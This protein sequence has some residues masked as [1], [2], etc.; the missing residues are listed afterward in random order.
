MQG[1]S[2]PEVNASRC[3]TGLIS[4]LGA[5]LSAGQRNDWPWFKEAWDAAMVKVYKGAWAEQ[6]S[7]WVQQV[8]CDKR[9]NAFSEFVYHETLRVFENVA[10]LHV[11][12]V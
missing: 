8:L 1:G 3:S 4:R 7:R 2:E 12:G 11:P 9:N 10:A 6:F 5:G